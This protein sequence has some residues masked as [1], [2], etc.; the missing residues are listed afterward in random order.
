MLPSTFVAI[1][2][3]ILFY[4]TASVSSR[5]SG[6]G[7]QSRVLG[8]LGG[9]F[10]FDQCIFFKSHGGHLGSKHAPL[11]PL[12]LNETLTGLMNWS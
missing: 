6:K 10:S 7:E 11:A 2:S 3:N 12:P 8:M 5:H 9:Y 4:I 1:I